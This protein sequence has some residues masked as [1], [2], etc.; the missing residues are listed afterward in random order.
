MDGDSEFLTPLA[1]DGKQ[2]LPADGGE[3]VPPGGQDLATVMN[4]DVVPDR[5]IPGEPL[6]ESGVGVLDTSERLVRKHDPESERLVRVVAFPYLDLV[7]GVKELDQGRQVQARR[8]TTDDRDLQ[9]RLRGAQLS[10]RSRKRCSLPVAVRGSS[11]ANSIALGYLYGAISPL[12]KSCSAL[13]GSGPS[14]APGCSTTTALTIMPRSSSGA[15][16]TAASAT[17]GCRSS[18][19]STSGPA[20]L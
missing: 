2:P 19:S 11:S 9:R 8:A 12:T 3:C 6:E 14:S 5:E 13:T 16:I 7:A 10:S 20:M 17:A 18:A 1:Q 4:V 15:P